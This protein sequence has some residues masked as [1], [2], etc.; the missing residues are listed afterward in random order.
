MP[1]SEAVLKHSSQVEE[2]G[3]PRQ[4]EFEIP[5]CALGDAARWQDALDLGMRVEV[6]GFLAPRS[7]KSRNAVLHV[8]TIKIL[9]GN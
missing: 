4:V 7:A 2:A 3:R 6:V 5:L 8:I 1:V 9:E